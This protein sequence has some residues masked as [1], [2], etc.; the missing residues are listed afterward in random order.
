MAR[1]SGGSPTRRTGSWKAGCPA[2]EGVKDTK[3]QALADLT[4]KKGEE[5]SGGIWRG[6]RVRRAAATAA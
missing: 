3:S 5:H 6:S 2:G 1:A 4:G